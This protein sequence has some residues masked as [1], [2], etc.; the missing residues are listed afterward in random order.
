VRL[1]RR[2]FLAWLAMSAAARGQTNTTGYDWQGVNRVVAIGDVHGDKDALTAV[3]RMAALIDSSDRWIGGTTHVVQVGDVPAR[4]PQTRQALDL[5]MRLEREAL[6]A[7]GRVHAL[8]GNHEAG[9]MQ[10]D[11]RNVLPAEFEEFRTADSEK[12][13]QA[14]YDRE[15]E[16]LRRRGEWRATATAAAAFRTSWFERHPP[17]W[18]EH[19][20]AFAPMGTYGSWI[21][22]NNA[23]VKVNDTLFV[24]GGISP[25]YVAT[26]PSTI[27]DGIRGELAQPLGSPAPLTEEVASPLRYRG[28]AEDEVKAPVSHVERVLAAQGV[29]RIVIGHTVTRTA[30]LPRYNAR[31]VN[32]DIGLSR[33]YGRPPACLVLEGRSA[34]VWHRQTKIEFPEPGTAD[35]TAYLRA[36]VAADEPPSP[37]TELLLGR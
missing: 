21:R 25:K 27:N 1:G 36:V 32:V 16:A 9:L 29:R 19:R 30:I 6:A 10:G 35:D 17:G 33:F 4:G 23:I 24:H 5:L 3:L 31:V 37:V 15:V 13:L 22:R 28:L 8:I 20:E 14:A 26:R 2:C 7:G 34:Y 11:L 18:V 12:R